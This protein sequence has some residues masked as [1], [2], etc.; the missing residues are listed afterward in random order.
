[1]YRRANG[2]LISAWSYIPVEEVEF[3]SRDRTEV[4][5]INTKNKTDRCRL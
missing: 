1:M 3:G 4:T 5:I 2:L